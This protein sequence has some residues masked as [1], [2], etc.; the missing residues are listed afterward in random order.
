MSSVLEKCAAAGVAACDVGGQIL[1][2][3]AGLYRKKD[4]GDSW[5]ETG[6]D[7]TKQRKGE[8]GENRGV[9]ILNE[10][11]MAAKDTLERASVIITAAKCAD[12]QSEPVE[13]FGQMHVILTGDFHQLQ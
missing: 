10:A 7:T 13:P 8:S 5:V 9:L 1:H 4:E 2:S 12:G 11:S 3:W 6:S